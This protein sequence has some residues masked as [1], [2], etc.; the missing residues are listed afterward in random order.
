MAGVVSQVRLPAA[1]GPRIELHGERRPLLRLVEWT[2][3][4]QQRLEHLLDRRCD[5]LFL[6]DLE[7]LNRLRW[8]AGQHGSPSFL[9]ARSPSRADRSAILRSARSLIRSSWWPQK[10]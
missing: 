7:R 4:L 1:A 2:E 8:S 5:L 10:R 9:L 6:R 3:M